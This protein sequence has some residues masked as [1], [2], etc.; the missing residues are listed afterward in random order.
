MSRSRTPGLSLGLLRPG[1]APFTK[2]YGFRDR[3]RELPATPRTLYGIASVTKSFTAIAILRLAEHGLLKVSDPV[4]RYLPELRIPGASSRRPI[5]I[6]HFLTH[7]S[8]LPPLPSIY[9]TSMHSVRRDPPYDPRIARRVGIDPDH[10]PI[11]TYEE[12]MRYLSET[13]YAL[14]GAPGQFFSY[15]NE[16]FGLLGAIIERTSGRTY[17]GFLEEELLR[18][19]G[20]SSTIFDTGILLRQPEVTTLYSPRWTGRRHPLV[21]S[22]EWWEDACLRAA[23]ALRTNV[24]D[25]LRYVE[26]FLTGGRVGRERIVSAKSIEEM[27]RPRILV[28]RGV[29]YGYGIAVRPEYHG[30]RLVF[31]GGG[32]KGV[33][34]SIVAAP[35]RGVAG[36]AL[37]N[38][39]GAPA[40]RWLEAAVNLALHVP[41]KTRFEEIPRPIR[42]RVPLRPYAGWYCSGEG[43]WIEVR[44]RSNHLR[45]DY[46]GIEKISKNFRL[47]PAGN[48][49]FVGRRGGEATSVRFLRSPSGRIEGMFEGWRIVRRRR[50]SD[51]PLARKGRLTW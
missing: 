47:R 25:L 45:A 15:S 32:L 37:S 21:P 39:D 7:S 34:S 42:H 23:G 38:A 4:V 6:H 10:A 17:E 44:A 14:L 41:A 20:M 3:E 48:D 36:A 1:Q 49:V 33:S 12:L 9:Y 26:L 31:H 50:A 22:E 35:E 29:H 5:R 43:I 19:A 8:G 2:G 46:R 11:D 30:T 16:G 18:P 40:E 51:L 27:L 24:V 13:K 28:G